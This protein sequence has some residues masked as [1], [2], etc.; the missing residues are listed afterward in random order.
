VQT[1]NTDITRRQVQAIIQRTLEEDDP[2]TWEGG[3]KAARMSAYYLKYIET[4][5]RQLCFE[6]FIQCNAKKSDQPSFKRLLASAQKRYSKELVR[7]DDIFSS[8]SEF[9]QFLAKKFDTEIP[10]ERDSVWR[11]VQ[12]LCL[13]WTK[14]KVEAQARASNVAA[15]KFVPHH[16]QIVILLMMVEVRVRMSSW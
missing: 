16:T 6:G 3:M 8:D 12:R 4:E 14:A 7:V 2:I 11:E 15:V 13:S 1:V 10:A 5:D 9:S